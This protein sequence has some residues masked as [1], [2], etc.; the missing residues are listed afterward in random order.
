MMF[1]I[2]L[3]RVNAMSEKDFLEAF[4]NIAEHS[5]WVAAAAAERRPFTDLDAMIDA[6]EEAVRAAPA[7]RQLELLRAHPDLAGKARAIA[8]ASRREQAAAGL[9]SLSSG[10][11]A[12][13]TALNDRYREKFGFPFIYAVKGAPKHRILAAFEERLGNSFE[14]ELD[15]ALSQVSRILRFRLAERVEQ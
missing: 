3:S 8:E 6:F 5:P 15:N 14:R 2:A 10:E 9:D 7:E 4:G 11:L 13:F 12:R 1:V